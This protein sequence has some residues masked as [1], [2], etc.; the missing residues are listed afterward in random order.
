MV[1]IIL[2]LVLAGTAAVREGVGISVEAQLRRSHML[3][4]VVSVFLRQGSI[5][6]SWVPALDL[7]S[8][9]AVR[10]A[11][12]ASLDRRQLLLGGIEGLYSIAGSNCASFRSRVV[13]IYSRV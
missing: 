9:L 3:L 6:L 4:H 1:H 10:Y 2:M 8:V 7:F 13:I 5:I 11:W 12:S